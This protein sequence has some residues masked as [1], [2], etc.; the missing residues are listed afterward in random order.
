[1]EDMK[2]A[3]ARELA[4]NRDTFNA[5]FKARK[6]LSRS[7]QADDFYHVLADVVA[8]VVEAVDLAGLEVPA[9]AHA[10][11]G[12]AL[13][14]TQRSLLGLNSRHEFVERVW[15]ELLPQVAN[16]VAK[17][18]H[19]VT[20]AVS[21]AAYHLG[22]RSQGIQS[23]WLK[24]MKVVA[25]ESPDLQAFLDAGVVVAWTSGMTHWRKPA[26]EAWSRLDSTLNKITLR[27]S[28]T[29]T[30]PPEVLRQQLTEAF[31]EPAGD[32]NPSL[33]IV[34]RTGGFRGFAGPFL[35]PPMVYSNGD[36]VF[37]ADSNGHHRVF[38]DI[39]GATIERTNPSTP[40]DFR[41]AFEYSPDG[42]IAAFGEAR[43]FFELENA[44]ST[45]GNNDFMA[46]TLPH[47]HHIW[48]VARASDDVGYGRYPIHRS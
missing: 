5:M 44:S 35:N 48:V 14:L 43:K 21:N 3:M 32:K 27:V 42:T 12:I 37:A 22:L 18:P 17:H 23:Q 45:A 28:S 20:T 25:L 8:P 31:Q 29:N 47:S 4:A 1:M 34:Y 33:Q 15:K 30:Y 19:D 6:T 7:L 41:S 40:T 36:R 13:T 38:A 26:L 46:V 24:T 16:L 2:G 10:L 11:Y 9:T 39:F